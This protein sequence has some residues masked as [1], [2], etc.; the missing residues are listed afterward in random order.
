MTNIPRD[1]CK[2]TSNK[3]VSLKKKIW[4]KHKTTKKIYNKTNTQIKKYVNNLFQKNINKKPIIPFTI[5]QVWHDK[6]DMPKSVKESVELIKRDNPEFK[7]ILYGE[8]DCEKFIRENF[9]QRV[10]NAYHSI[11]P[12]AIKAD[13]F[14]Y[15]YLY[16][17]GGIYLDSKYYC[18]NNFKFVLLTDKEYFCRDFNAS[19]NGIYNAIIICKPKNKIIKKAI[20]ESV[21]N[22][23][24]KYY[25]VGGHCP[26]GP[27]MLKKLFSIN[28]I[29][30]LELSHEYINKTNRFILLNGY[31]I[32]KYHKDYKNE[33]EQKNNHWK[34]YWEDKTMYKD[35]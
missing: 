12:Y 18:I 35:C 1:V 24:N 7:H 8:N 26:T 30:N 11:V 3:F 5:C 17:N 13:L 10:L 16:K 6:T 33:K 25:G 31:R 15:C 23:E 21:N 22:I 19:L 28:Q 29:N 27:L 2:L 20:Y 32:L 4:N 9:S 34:L 14:R